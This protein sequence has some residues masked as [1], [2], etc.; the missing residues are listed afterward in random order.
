MSE[1]NELFV[2]QSLREFRASHFLAEF[3][4]CEYFICRYVQIY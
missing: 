2:F 1:L 3:L 4:F